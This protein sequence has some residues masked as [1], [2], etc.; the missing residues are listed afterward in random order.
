MCERAGAPDSP[1]LPYALTH[2]S[3]WKRNSPK[4]DF[5]FFHTFRAVPSTITAQ[6]RLTPFF[7]GLAKEGRHG[8][9]KTTIF[10][11]AALAHSHRA[12]SASHRHSRSRRSVPAGKCRL[13][14]S[15][16]PGRIWVPGELERLRE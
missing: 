16:A 11:R 15:V 13:E 6:G 1:A 4:L 5:R 2:R 12:V 9:R 3:A 14:R 8:D 7:R 10:H